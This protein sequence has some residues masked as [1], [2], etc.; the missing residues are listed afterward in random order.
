[1]T[2]G[3]AE[4]DDLADLAVG[5]HLLCQL[6]RVGETLVLADHQALALLFGNPHHLFTVGEGDGHGL[7]AENMLAGLQGLDAELGVRVVGS[8][9]GNRVDFGIGKEF[10]R[11]VVD[12]AA[13]FGSHVFGA[14][15]GRVKEADELAAG[16]F[17]VLG[18]VPDLGNFAAA[19][20]TD[21]NHGVFSFS[22]RIR[23]PLRRASWE[24][25]V[26]RK[27]AA[28]CAMRL[29]GLYGVITAYCAGSRHGI[30][31]SAA[32]CCSRD[33]RTPA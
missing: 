6:V 14:G 3:G 18:D 21:F 31:Q 29:C 7:L 20:D 16:V 28:V 32:F 25:A 30:R 11:R 12:L 17:I 4:G 9:D 33:D 10:I 5:N 27:K 13:V 26:S 2:E 24:T 15:S 23:Y 22:V 19:K 8:A 1:M